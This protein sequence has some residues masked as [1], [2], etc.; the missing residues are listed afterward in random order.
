MIV[1]LN[2][3][4][5]VNRVGTPWERDIAHYALDRAFVV[6]EGHPP[7][8]LP[9]STKDTPLGRV[10]AAV[11]FGFGNPDVVTA[12]KTNDRVGEGKTRV[13]Q[14]DRP[15]SR[16]CLARYRPVPDSITGWVADCA[17]SVILSVAD[18]AP[19]AAGL[20]VTLMAQLLAAAREVEQVE[21]S[22]KSVAF[23]PVTLMP[24]NDKAVV[25]V[26]LSVTVLVALVFTVCVPK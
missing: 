8:P 5:V 19:L 20:K 7:H 4:G 2:T 15:W 23:V 1:L 17:L 16:F 14:F 13:G 11:S 9:Q 12:N 18:R 26:F 6:I 10:P 24:V 22:V 25:P 3:A 21:V